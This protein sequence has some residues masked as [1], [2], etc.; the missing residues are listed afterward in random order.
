MLMRIHGE[1]DEMEVSLFEDEKLKDGSGEKEAEMLRGHS[2]S[3]IYICN[4]DTEVIVISLKSARWPPRLKC[5]PSLVIRR[6]RGV[7][8]PP[9]IPPTSNTTNL[10][11]GHHLSTSQLPPMTSIL[12]MSHETVSEN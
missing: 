12:G 10:E 6:Q 7:P 1:G 3:W 4:L 5:L 2:G 11:S 8:Y 9:R